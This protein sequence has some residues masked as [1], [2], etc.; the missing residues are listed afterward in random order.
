MYLD[1]FVQEDN[2]THYCQCRKIREKIEKNG[3]KVCVIHLGKKEE[4]FRYDEYEIPMRHSGKNI[5][6]TIE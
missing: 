5:H 3:K 1:T 4:F 6:Y 2:D